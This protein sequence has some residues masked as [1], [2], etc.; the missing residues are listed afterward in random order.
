MTG[1]QRRR[2]FPNWPQ[3]DHVDLAVIGIVFK[4]AAVGPCSGFKG[5]TLVAGVT[6]AVNVVVEGTIGCA[7]LQA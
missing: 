4:P 7:G 1:G 6:P 2:C 3:L 5:G